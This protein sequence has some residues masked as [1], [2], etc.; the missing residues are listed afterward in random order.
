MLETVRV[1]F[2]FCFCF[3]FFHGKFAMLNFYS[4]KQE[5]IN[6]HDMTLT[7]VSS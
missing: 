1:V 2:C 3:L 7:E 5:Q 4:T 6:G